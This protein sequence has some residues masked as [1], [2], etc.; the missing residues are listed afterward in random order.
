MALQ[1]IHRLTDWAVGLRLLY[2]HQ[3]W[4]GPYNILS[5]TSQSVNLCTTGNAMFYCLLYYTVK[6]F[7]QAICLATSIPHNIY[8]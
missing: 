6:T 8:L 3:L 1:V 4:F 2:G 7:Y 5:P